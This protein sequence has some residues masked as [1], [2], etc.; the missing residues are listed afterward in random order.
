[1]YYVLWNMYYVLKGD[2][3]QAMGDGKKA[4][5]EEHRGME[6]LKAWCIERGYYK[7]GGL[8]D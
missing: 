3:R 4:W 8:Q 1:M 6:Q 7:A 5:S 2:G